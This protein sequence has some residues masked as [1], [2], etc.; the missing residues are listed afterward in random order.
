MK[1]QEAKSISSEKQNSKKVRQLILYNDEINTFDFVI[2]SLI[3]VCNHEPEQAEQC[4]LIVHHNGKCSVKTGSLRK[5]K[6]MCSALCD[7]GLSA[8]IE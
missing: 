7:R 5:L 2:E 3:E 1:H 4:S 6:P 8:V